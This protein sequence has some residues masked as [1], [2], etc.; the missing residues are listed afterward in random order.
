MAFQAPLTARHDQ[1]VGSCRESI[2]LSISLV[3]VLVADP[4]AT[5]AELMAPLTWARALADTQSGLAN[6]W[7]M[8]LRSRAILSAPKENCLVE[9]STR[10]PRPVKAEVATRQP[11]HLSGWTIQPN[12]PRMESSFLPIHRASGVEGAVK[13]ASSKYIRRLTPTE[14]RNFTV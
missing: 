14:R 6:K 8:A 10:I 11:T 12:L 7:S 2:T 13:R 3:W 5:H 9:R 1:P 4:R